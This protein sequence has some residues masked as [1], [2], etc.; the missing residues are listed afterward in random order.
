M[1]TDGGRGLGRDWAIHFRCVLEIALRIRERVSIRVHPFPSVFIRGF[2]F[3]PCRDAQRNGPVKKETGGCLRRPPGNTFVSAGRQAESPTLVGRMQVGLVAPAMMTGAVGVTFFRLAKEC[4]ICMEVDLAG[5]MPR[6]TGRG[7]RGFFRKC[8]ETRGGGCLVVGQRVWI[9]ARRTVRTGGRAGRDK[10]TA[11]TG[12]ADEWGQ[13]N[14]NQR[15]SSFRPI[16]L[17]PFVCQNSC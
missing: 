3:R 4:F 2:Q 13:T 8:A 9:C 17:P 10:K 6:R 15:S 12:M 16:R 14:G 5:V 11:G 1:D 7:L